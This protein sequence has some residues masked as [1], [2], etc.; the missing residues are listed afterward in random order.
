MDWLSYGNSM[1]AEGVNL[2]ANTTAEKMLRKNMPLSEIMDF[3]GLTETA[4]KKLAEQLKLK[5]VVG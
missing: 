5:V 2:Q 1:K 4:V 3:G